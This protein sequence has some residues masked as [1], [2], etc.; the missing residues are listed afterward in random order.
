MVIVVYTIGDEIYVTTPEF[1]DILRN[2]L[3]EVGVD[4]DEC[5]RYQRTLDEDIP[6]VDISV[7]CCIHVGGCG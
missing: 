7:S 5:D 1:E 4:P 6:S 2:E 3:V